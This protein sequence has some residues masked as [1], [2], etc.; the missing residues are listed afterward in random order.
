MCMFSLQHQGTGCVC[1]HGLRPGGVTAVLCTG[2]VVRAQGA[3]EQQEPGMEAAAP[4]ACAVRQRCCCSC[5]W[6]TRVPWM[7][8]FTYL[9]TLLSIRGGLRSNCTRFLGQCCVLLLASPQST[10]GGA[11]LGRGASCTAVQTR[12]VHHHVR[13]YTAMLGEAC[14]LVP[15]GL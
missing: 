1:T 2:Q 11:P 12:H 6:S 7:I 5:R 4:C 14:A 10:W 8:L 13:G 9:H 15:A 3:G